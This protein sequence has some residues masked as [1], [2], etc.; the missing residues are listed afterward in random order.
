MLSSP[1]LGSPSPELAHFTPPHSVSL[2]IFSSSA[3]YSP[4]NSIPTLL[5]LKIT[6]LETHGEH[7]VARFRT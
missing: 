7:I 5:F 4:P 3:G 6:N 1:I 2:P